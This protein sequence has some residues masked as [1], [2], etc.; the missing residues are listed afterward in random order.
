MQAEQKIVNSP[1]N[2]EYLPIDGL[3]VFK[4]ATVDLLLGANH[5]A[6]KDVSMSCP[7]CWIVC[8][9]TVRL[10]THSFTGTTAKEMQAT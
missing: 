2:K 5:P 4:K 8:P 10:I 6:I 3:D 1:G 9:T 7:C